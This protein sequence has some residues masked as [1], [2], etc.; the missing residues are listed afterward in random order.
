MALNEKD[1]LKR[2]DDLENR[3]EKLE[4]AIAGGAKPNSGKVPEDYEQI[5]KYK[6]TST[7]Y[8]FLTNKGRVLEYSSAIT[9]ESGFRWNRFTM[10]DENGSK[11]LP[12]WL[13][14]VKGNLLAID[15]QDLLK[16]DTLQDL[17]ECVA[18]LRAK[19]RGVAGLPCLLP[20]MSVV[21]ENKTM[22]A[23]KETTKSIKFN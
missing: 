20:N 10:T 16:G 14:A 6:E 23:F 19:Y 15:E 4:K 7:S 8:Y 5:I 17:M 3:L 2:I 9:P 22:A 21:Y 11:L 13:L 18:A 12:D 1:L